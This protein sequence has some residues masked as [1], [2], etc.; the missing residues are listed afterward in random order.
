MLAVSDVTPLASGVWSPND[1]YP[2]LD[3]S[4][5]RTV[6][7]TARSDAWLPWGRPMA[8][9]RAAAT[10]ECM[11]SPDSVRCGTVAKLTSTAVECALYGSESMWASAS[12]ARA[13]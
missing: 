11:V 7:S 10:L 13:I 5:E 2:L 8:A 9:M 1:M 4:T 6:S 12:P 3:D